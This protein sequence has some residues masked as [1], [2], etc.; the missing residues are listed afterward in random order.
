VRTEVSRKSVAALVVECILDPKRFS[1]SN[2]G[3][4]KPNTDRDK[5]AFY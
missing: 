5:P 2:L 1:R 3:M 4:N